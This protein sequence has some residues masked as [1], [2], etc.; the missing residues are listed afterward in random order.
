MGKKTAKPAAKPEAKKEK[1]VGRN[2][3]IIKVLPEDTD[4]DMEQL[5]VDIENVLQNDVKDLD[6]NPVLCQLMGAQEEEIAFGLK[7]LKIQVAAPENMPG[8]TQ[9]I[10]DALSAI[11]GIQRVE[12]ELVT[13]L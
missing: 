6:G 9:P 3:C 1:V 8:G 5:K 7:A 4:M 10:E 12:V 11:P 13:R 2:A